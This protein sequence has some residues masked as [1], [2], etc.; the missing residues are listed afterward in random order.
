MKNQ[1]EAIKCITYDL[2]ILKKKKEMKKLIS[3]RVYIP[4]FNTSY[5]RN[6]VSDK[7]LL[8]EGQDRSIGSDEIIRDRPTFIS[9]SISIA[10]RYF[11]E[12]FSREWGYIKTFQF[13]FKI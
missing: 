13:F 7:R 10:L 9:I 1:W 6:E 8:H 5:M 3:L 4:A 2:F 12:I 11:E